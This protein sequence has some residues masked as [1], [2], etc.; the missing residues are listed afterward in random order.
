MHPCLGIF[1]HANQSMY[2]L[3]KH[4][5]LLLE[6]CYMYYMIMRVMYTCTCDN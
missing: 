3:A 2:A 4:D 5:M 6:Y 1:L